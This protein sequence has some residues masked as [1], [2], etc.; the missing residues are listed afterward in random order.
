MLILLVGLLALP[1]AGKACGWPVA[2]DEHPALIGGPGFTLN[3]NPVT[4]SYFFINLEFS[5]AEFPNAKVTI[6]NVLGQ[7]VYVAP[8]RKTEFATGKIRIELAD[9]KL[10]KGVYF[11]QVSSGDNTKTL[12][13]AVR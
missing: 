13:L 7:A 2:A 3:P 9:A 10:D 11:V 12:K 6:T 5:E 4:G 8:I 1:Q